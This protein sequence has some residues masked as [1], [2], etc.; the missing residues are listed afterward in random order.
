M[1]VFYGLFGNCLSSVVYLFLAFEGEHCIGNDHNRP[2]FGGD[3]FGW[4]WIVR[5]VAS[6]FV[7]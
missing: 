4:K 5:D 3:V 7:F 2:R 1:I 6:L